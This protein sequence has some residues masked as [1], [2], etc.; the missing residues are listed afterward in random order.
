MS[1]AA[2]AATEATSPPGCAAPPSTARVGL[3]LGICFGVCFVT[4]LISHWRQLAAR[5][6]SRS[7]PARRGATGVTQGLHVI[8]G[9]AA[10]PLLLVKLWTVYPKLFERPP[11]R[12]ARAGSRSH[13][14]RAAVDRRPGRRG[15]LPARHR[16]GQLRAVV[17]VGA[18]RFRPPTTPSPGSPIGAL[19]GAHRGQAADHP[20]RARRGRRRR[21]GTTAPSATEPGGLSRRGLLRTTWAAA[22][23]AVL[24]TAGNTVPLA[25]PRVGPRRSAPA[26]AR[27]A[28]RSTS[29]AAAARVVATATETRR[30]GSRVAYGD[31]EVGARPGPSCAAMPQTTETLPIAC[32]E[33]WSASGALDRRPGPRPARPRRGAGR[34]RR[35]GDVAAGAGPFRRH[36]RCPRT[37]PTTTAPCWRCG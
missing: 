20:Q 37:S 12:D 24:A 17:P 33:G 3:W 35:R 13:G 22:G 4:G 16:A 27:R 29:R 18:S 25:A 5:R 31:R 23:V 21:R 11:P 8:T 30:T 6:R 1:P 7:R 14:C 28:S 32:V 19:R 34:Q 9:T 26:T 15:D 36:R 10:V 2:R